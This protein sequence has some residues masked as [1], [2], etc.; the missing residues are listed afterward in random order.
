MP[1]KQSGYFFNGI[2][3]AGPAPAKRSG[4]APAKRTAPAKRSGSAPAKRTAPAKRSGSAPAKRTGSAA[5][6]AYK[7]VGGKVGKGAGRTSRKDAVSAG[8]SV[9]KS[10]IASG[11][12]PNTGKIYT[13]KRLGLEGPAK[14]KY[15]SGSSDYKAAIVRAGAHRTRSGSVRPSVAGTYTRSTTIASGVKGVRRG[16]KGL[17]K[18]SSTPSRSAS[19]TK[20]SRKA[21]HRPPSPRGHS[22]V[23]RT[24][25]PR[26]ARKK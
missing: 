15:K 16:V 20:R 5:I 1:A 10:R 9:R 2:E 11:T 7:S 4:S 6:R 17:Y 3:R 23:A 8:R 19:S 13:A 21:K 24:L 18:G 22:S 12:N 14:R 25:H 26:A